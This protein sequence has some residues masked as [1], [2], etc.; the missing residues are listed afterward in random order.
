VAL[1]K[2]KAKAAVVVAAA[3]AVVKRAEVAEATAGVML[4]AGRRVVL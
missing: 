4:V 3:T 1:L 2:P